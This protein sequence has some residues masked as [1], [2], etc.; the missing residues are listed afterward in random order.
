[1][2][3]LFTG[4]LLVAS[5]LIT[6]P[7]YGGG[8]C[9]VVYEQDDDV[10]GVM[11]NRPIGPQNEVMNALT[12]PL[13]SGE[14]PLGGENS[15]APESSSASSLGNRLPRDHSAV[16]DSLIAD[17]RSKMLHFGGPQSG[18]VVAVHQNEELAE[19]VTGQGVYVAAQ[20]HHLE[21]LVRRS[22]H[23][24]RLIVGHIRWTRAELQHELAA[25]LWHRLPATRQSVFG[26][27]EEMW[28]SMIRRATTRSMASWIGT[29]DL[30]NAYELN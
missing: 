19:A 14:Q 8:V 27:P 10:I 24:Y 28:P 4:Q 25:G 1:M 5:T 13:S 20:R 7:T 6:E 16:P 3:E 2:Q 11:L 15:S 12:N 29:P 21:D 26:A 30:P 18:P 22:P 9:L 17:I 23:S